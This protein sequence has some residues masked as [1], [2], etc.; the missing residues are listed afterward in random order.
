M[1]DPPKTSTDAHQI[2]APGQ[3]MPIYRAANLP[4]TDATQFGAL[5]EAAPDA[6]VIV[7]VAGRIVIVNSQTER[8]F[9]YSKHELLGQTLELL[10]PENLR[11]IHVGHRAAYVA[12]PRTRPMGSGL[13]LAARRK[14][15]QVFPVEISLSA[16]STPDGML[17]TSIVRDV[18]DRKRAEEALRASEARYRA[19]FDQTPIGV[20]LYDRTLHLTECNAALLRIVR[21][22]RDE[23][24]NFDLAALRDGRAVLTRRGRL[25]ADRVTLALAA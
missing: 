13:E 14:D 7:D 9:G 11:A 23:V 4:E 18:T 17:L 24:R 20:L 21:A 12:E 19:L 2:N 10:L 6:I 15:G 8:L 5:L 22:T 25:L 1:G 3:P 16:I